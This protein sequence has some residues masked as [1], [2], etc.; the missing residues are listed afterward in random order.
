MRIYLAASLFTQLER[1]W[2]R[3][4]AEAIEATLP[5]AKVTLPQDIKINGSYEDPKNNGVLFRQC[6]RGIDRAD[7]VLAIIDGADPD[8]GTSWEMGYSYAKGK[9]IIGVR[10]DF[11]PGAEHG[12]NIMLSR[13]CQNHVRDYSFQE[14]V[15]VVAKDIVRRL[16]RIGANGKKA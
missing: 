2:N 5:G 11:R 4:L 3:R 7:I 13:S 1:V 15:S 10:T 16:K 12:V 8:S 9:P 14:D 6:V